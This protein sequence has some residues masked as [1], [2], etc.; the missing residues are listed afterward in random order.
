MSFWKKLEKALVITGAILIIWTTVSF[1][2][3]VSQNTQP[4]IKPEYPNWN[5]FVML[6]GE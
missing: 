1:I 5:I 4:G 6:D 3:V 2:Q